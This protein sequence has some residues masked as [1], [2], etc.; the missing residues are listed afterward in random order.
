[1]PANCDHSPTIC[2]N[3]YRTGFGRRYLMPNR[4]PGTDSM[5]ELHRR[6]PRK[7]ASRVSWTE[8]GR[9]HRGAQRLGS[10]AMVE[11]GGMAA[12]REA[13]LTTNRHGGLSGGS[14]GFPSGCAGAE[15]AQLPFL[16]G[17]AIPQR[18][19]SACGSVVLSNDFRSSPNN[20]HVATASACP[21]CANDRDRGEPRGSAPPTPP[22]VRVRIRRFEKLR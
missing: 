4:Q 8:E 11:T 18:N 2:V 9:R 13:R 20:G 3:R 17:A 5:A 7:A 10:A 12:S 21:K 6:H 22:Y 16:D 1:M 14:K 15:V 19:S